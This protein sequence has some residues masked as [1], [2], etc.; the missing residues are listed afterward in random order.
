MSFKDKIF[1]NQ[2]PWGSNPSGG[3]GG[4]GSG[5]RREPPNIDEVIQNLQK[6]INKFIGGKSSGGKPILL[7]LNMMQNLLILIMINH[8]MMQDH[9]FMIFI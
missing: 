7:G 9:T 2:S 5:T 8:L 1:N 4:N 3:S 6:K